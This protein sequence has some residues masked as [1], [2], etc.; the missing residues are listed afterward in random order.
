[1][2]AGRRRCCSASGSP[3]GR[4]QCGRIGQ[5]FPSP[6]G[7]GAPPRFPPPFAAEGR[8]VLAALA[9][10][11]TPGRP[12]PMRRFDPS[13]RLRGWP[14]L[15]VAVND[16]VNRLRA[17]GEEPVIAAGSWVLPGELGV[18]CAGH[19]IVHSV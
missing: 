2:S 16:V 18:Y 8:P 4:R 15:G 7:G 9:G 5:F 3:S 19:P 1:M 14:T 13:C 12:L 10:P 6:P 17:G 11:P